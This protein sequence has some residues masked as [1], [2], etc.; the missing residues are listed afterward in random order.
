MAGLRQHGVR[1]VRQGR[2]DPAE[3]HP[4]ALAQHVLRRRHQRRGRRA[5]LRAQG[6]LPLRRRHVPRLRGERRRPHHRAGAAARDRRRGQGGAQARCRG[7]AGARHPWRPYGDDARARGRRRPHDARAWT[8]GRW[9]P[10]GAR[11]CEGEPR[12]HPNRPRRLCPVDG[13]PRRGHGR[14]ARRDPR[15]AVQHLRRHGRQRRELRARGHGRGHG[16]GARTRLRRGSAG[17]FAAG[18][19]GRRGHLHAAGR[20]GL[21]RRGLPRRERP[22]VGEPRLALA[23]G[24]WHEGAGAGRRRRLATEAALPDE[25]GV[26]PLGKRSR[27]RRRRAPAATLPA[28]FEAAGARREVARL[29]HRRRPR[30]LH[31]AGRRGRAAV[32][33]R[34]PAVP[35]VARALAAT[36]ALA[37]PLA[38]VDQAVGAGVLAAARA[39]AP[40][41]GLPRGRPGVPA[42]VA[43]LH[44][45]RPDGA[46]APKCGSKDSAGCAGDG[47]SARASSH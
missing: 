16:H 42:V 1:G 45:G 2:D 12:R 39:G 14:G 37:L 11:A 36:A 22:L 47:P 32:D 44:P 7:E 17:A 30:D 35:G 29:A 38:D 40:A 9:R 43:G 13:K 19:E 15:G 31:R 4:Q 8:R 46:A 18:R 27:G 33:G 21:R 34:L 28:A 3:A 23:V 20:G 6:G 41:I 24:V 5:R 25:G 26:A 10:Q